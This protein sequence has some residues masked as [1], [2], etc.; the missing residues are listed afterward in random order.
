MPQN[1]QRE[2]YWTRQGACPALADVADPRSPSRRA[3]VRLAIPCMQTPA[4]PLDIA[5][6]RHDVGWLAAGSS[7]PTDRLGV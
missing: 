6:L 5:L 4:R 1:I 7:T 3:F 2:T